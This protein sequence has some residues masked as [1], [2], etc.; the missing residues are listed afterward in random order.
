MVAMVFDL[1]V[2]KTSSLRT[3]RGVT[4]LGNG[5]GQGGLLRCAHSATF[6]PYRPR[7]CMFRAGVRKGSSDPRQ[8]DAQALPHVEYSK[9]T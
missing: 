9:C 3:N 2:K 8:G 7:S 6:L 1:V 5:E 4:V